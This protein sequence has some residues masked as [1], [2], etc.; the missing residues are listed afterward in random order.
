KIIRFWDFKHNKQL[1]IFNEHT[2]GVNGIEFSPFNG[3]L[4]VDFSLRK[5][6]IIIRY[7][8]GVRFLC[9]ILYIANFKRFQFFK[10]NKLSVQVPL[11]QLFVEITY[12]LSFIAPNLFIFFFCLKNEIKLI[13][14]YWTRTLKIKLGWIN[15]FDKIIMKYNIILF[16]VL[17]HNHMKFT[18]FFLNYFK[19]YIKKIK[20]KQITNNK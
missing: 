7:V 19:L 5:S 2:G 12:Q 11:F 13:I 14:K 8:L 9:N 10:K 15:D 20:S 3:G 1:Q 16:L 18:N 6:I 17:F 4:N